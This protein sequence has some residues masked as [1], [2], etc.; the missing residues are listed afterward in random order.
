MPKAKGAARKAA[1]ETLRADLLAAA[2]PHVAFD[3]WSEAVLRSAAKDLDVDPALAANAFPGGGRELIAFYSQEIDRRCLEALEALPLEEMKVRDKIHTGVM[4][5]LE[6]LEPDKEA[7]RR[8]LSF[9]ALPHNAPLAAK[10]LYRTVDALWY[11][12]GDRATDYNFYTKRGLLAGVY[13]STLLF[14]LN[15]SSADYAATH[16]FLDRRIAEVLKIGGRLGK[17]MAGLMNFPDRLAARMT[18]PGAR[19]PLAGLRSGL[20]GG[21]RA[22]RFR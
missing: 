6:L 20:R 14:W 9:L 7:V 5:R 12:A 17:G 22:G 8:G 11:A 10:L 18:Q 1:G 19:G 13:S 21:F 15:D 3:G 16:G 2:L 4:T